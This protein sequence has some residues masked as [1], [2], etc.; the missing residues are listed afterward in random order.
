MTFSRHV[1]SV[2]PLNDISQSLCQ[3]DVN[4]FSQRNHT[5]KWEL[6]GRIISIFGEFGGS[7]EHTIQSNKACR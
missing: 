4:D 3:D 6:R 2:R 7:I 1:L 5:G